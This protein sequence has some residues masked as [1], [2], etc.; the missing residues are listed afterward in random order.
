M[1]DIN[2]VL[3]KKTDKQLD[4]LDL[5][6][7]VEDHRDDVHSEFLVPAGFLT[8]GASIPK[9]LRWYL[10]P[11]GVMFRAS[12]VHD[13]LYAEKPVDREHADKIF[14]RIVIEDTGRRILAN[15]AYAGLRA[16]GG[17]AWD[18]ALSQDTRSFSAER[19]GKTAK[20]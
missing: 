1:I 9:S 6:E 17:D 20:N 5:Y 2:G 16:F 4:G 8:N 19:F 11:L 14:K 12:V 18:R 3:L 15:L 13:Y 7:L 10:K